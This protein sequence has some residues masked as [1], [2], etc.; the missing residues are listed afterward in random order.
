MLWE[1]R[2][3]MCPGF[4]GQEGLSWEGDFWAETAESTGLAKPEW[5]RARRG[6]GS[7][8]RQREQRVQSSQAAEPKAQ[9]G[10]EVVW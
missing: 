10:Q 7:H 8:F 3:G 1:P 4:K 5:M 9:K 2:W 6:R